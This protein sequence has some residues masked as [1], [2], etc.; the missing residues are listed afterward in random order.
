MATES[1]KIILKQSEKYECIICDFSSSKKINYNNHLF[2]AKH[3]KRTISNNLATNQQQKT[4]F[5]CDCGK[6]YSD[7]T[8]LW[9]HK[10]KCLIKNCDDE[11]KRNNSRNKS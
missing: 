4:S 2:T 6:E 5:S 8:G 11:K 10:K 3:Q 1:T 9:R 7:R